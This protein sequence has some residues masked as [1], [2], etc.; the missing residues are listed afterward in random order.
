MFTLATLATLVGT[1]GVIIVLIAY[2]L[3]QIKKMNPYSFLYS[4]LNFLGSLMILYSLFYQWNFPAVL[5]EIVWGLI[6]LY[7]MY[8]ALYF[9]K[10]KY[11]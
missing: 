11:L 4:F 6:S 9:K 8:R 10:K 7:G 3:L 5:I 1:L 2:M